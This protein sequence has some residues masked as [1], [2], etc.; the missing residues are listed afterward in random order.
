MV[1]NSYRNIGRVIEANA[2]SYIVKSRKQAL[3]N[4]IALIWK[5]YH[6]NFRVLI[7]TC[8]LQAFKIPRIWLNVRF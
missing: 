2:I 5:R 1:M 3:W 8:S 4:G 7:F 6:N